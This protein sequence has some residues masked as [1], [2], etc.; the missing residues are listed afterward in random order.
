MANSQAHRAA[1]QERA[2]RIRRRAIP[3]VDILNREEGEALFD[4]ETRKLLGISG[5]EFLRRLD[6]GQYEGPDETPEARK[7]NGLVMMLPFARRTP[8]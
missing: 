8:A 7:V 2:R 5:D 4:A 1:R 6:A 3:G